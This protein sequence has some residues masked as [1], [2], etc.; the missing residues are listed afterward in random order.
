VITTV[1]SII[2]ELLESLV[3]A[4]TASRVASSPSITAFDV[5]AAAKASVCHSCKTA[6]ALVLAAELMNGVSVGEIL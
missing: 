5:D 3:V 6:V 1:L 2:C 4:V